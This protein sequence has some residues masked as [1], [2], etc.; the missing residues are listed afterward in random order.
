MAKANI[1]TRQV[2]S[3][4][5]DKVPPG[6]DAATFFSPII[7]EEVRKSVPLFHGSSRE[8]LRGLLQQIMQLMLTD[9]YEENNF[10]INLMAHAEESSIIVTG[11]YLIIRTAI[12]NKVALKSMTTDLEKMNVPV[13]LIT[14]IKILLQ[15]YRM[16]LEKSILKNVVGF[17]TISKLRWRIDVIISSGLVSRVMRPR[18]MMQVVSLLHNRWLPNLCRVFS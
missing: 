2:L 15:R 12:K 10:E 4:D 7:P 18:I 6:I 14:D 11:L 5:L 16:H 9:K 13:N 8:V 3:E 17:P 1:K